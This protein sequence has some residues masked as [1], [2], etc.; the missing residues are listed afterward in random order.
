MYVD[1]SS[2]GVTISTPLLLVAAFA[3]GSQALSKF[4]RYSELL[5]T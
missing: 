2:S 3:L 5:R 1:F 4:K